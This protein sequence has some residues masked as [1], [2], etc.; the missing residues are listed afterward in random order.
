MDHP[1]AR[2]LI[3]LSL[4]PVNRIPVNPFHASLIHT[5][6]SLGNPT[7]LCAQNILRGR[8][9]GPVGVQN[10]RRSAGPRWPQAAPQ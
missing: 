4:I 1:V 7:H 8:A 5:S 10:P 6:L 9:K 2:H 3:A